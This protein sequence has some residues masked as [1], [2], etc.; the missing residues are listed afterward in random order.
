[1]AYTDSDVVSLCSCMFV[2]KNLSFMLPLF[3]R[4]LLFLSGGNIICI[5][6]ALIYMYVHMYMW[7]IVY[8]EKLECD[9]LLKEVLK[10][11]VSFF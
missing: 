2:L 11:F 10:V 7:G 9:G 3:T 4:K 1:M 5:S 6:E 8:R